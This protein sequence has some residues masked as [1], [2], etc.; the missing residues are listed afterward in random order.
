[1]CTSEIIKTA[2]LVHHEGV[3]HESSL[4]KVVVLLVVV[5]DFHVVGVVFGSS[6]LILLLR[7]AGHFVRN[8]AVELV[9][10]LFPVIVPGFD[11]FVS[12]RIRLLIVRSLGLLAEGN[13]H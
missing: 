3:G 7:T 2:F 1:M 13:L 12:V 9:E 5:V 6:P 10:P 4:T 8:F 11:C